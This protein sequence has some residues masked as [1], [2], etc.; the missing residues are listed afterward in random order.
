M[1]ALFL[2]YNLISVVLVLCISIKL[3]RAGV[4]S[5]VPRWVEKLWNRHWAVCPFAC[6][7]HPLAFA[8][9]NP[10][11]L[12]LY[13]SVFCFWTVR[14]NFILFLPYVRP[15][16]NKTVIT[17]YV[18]LSI[19]LI[20]LCLDSLSSGG[21]RGIP[22]IV[23]GNANSDNR[24]SLQTEGNHTAQWFRTLWNLN[25]RWIRR[26]IFVVTTASFTNVFSKGS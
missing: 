18:S 8:L 16:Y 2:R 26:M 3:E 19:N 23:C 15:A 22:V 17:N 10:S 24:P 6:N 12:S 11:L 9:V 1:I 14:V 20:C 13:D 5:T 25:T 7:A 21:E 4:R